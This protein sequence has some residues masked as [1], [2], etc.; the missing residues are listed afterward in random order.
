MLKRVHLICNSHI[1][2]IWQ[3]E[4]EEGAAAAIATF[5]SAVNLADKYDYI[6]CHNEVTLYK[7]TQRFAPA[8][9]EDI[10]RLVKE[11][12]W[13]IMGGWYLQPDCLLPE[14]EGFIRQIQTG[15][16]YF[17]E[18]FG[19]E[20]PTVA[21]NFDAF[22]HSRGV[23][24][25]VKKCGQNGYLFMRP[26]SSYIKEQLRLPAECFLWEGYDGSVIKAAR[27]TDYCSVMGE[28]RAKIERDIEYQK[29]TEIGLACWGLGNHGG[30]PSAKDLEDIAALM[31]ESDIEI[32]HST[33]ERYFADV[34]PEKVFAESLIPCM[35]G[36]YTSMIHLK[37]RYRELERQL[38]FTEKIASAAALEKRFPYPAE[39]VADAVEAMLNVQFHDVLPG[40]TIRSGEENG[41]TFTEHGIHL[42]NQVR[43]DAF[44]ALC[45]GQTPA[46]AGVYPI[47][48]FNPKAYGGR[49][50]AECELSISATEAFEEE[51][52]QIELFDES[53]NAVPCQ[54]V[55]EG[56]NQ[57]VDRRKRFVF[58]TD[59]APFGIT[60]LTA[61]SVLKKKPRYRTEGDVVYA[62]AGKKIVIGAKTGLIESF[63]VRGTEYAAGGLFAPICYEDTPDPWGMRQTHVGD[64]PKRFRLMKKPDGV[65]K[66]M[67]PLQIVEDGAVYL[68]AEAFF[69]CGPTRLRIGYKI[70]KNN[71]FADID[72][73]LFPAETDKAYKLCLPIEAESFIGEQVFGEEALFTDGREC[74]AHNYIALKKKE[75]YF[76]IVTPSTYGCSYKDGKAYITLLKTATYCAHPAGERPLLREGIFIDKIDMRQCD[77][78]FRIQP[79]KKNELKRNADVFVEKPYAINVFPTG[80]DCRGAMPFKIALDN[81]DI[82]VVTVKKSEQKDGYIIRLFNGKETPDSAALIFGGVGKKFDFGKFEVKTILFDGNR[83]QE[84]DKMYI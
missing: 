4:W 46:E 31:R 7:Y 24:Q 36:C 70:Y 8:L 48:V 79:A 22:G 17:K 30:G 43:A 38:L 44:F 9:F 28:S 54:T 19:I 49:Q 68:G 64:R 50:I 67:S 29:D 27:V 71:D 35:V 40:T 80:E 34:A 53:G 65:F 5:Q 51:Y 81:P 26:W 42:L 82:S 66:G 20:Q 56:S 18:K 61:K 84:C 37:Q 32:L 23:V 55:K 73:T 33:P 77:Y 58:E 76:E 2:H 74:V 69:A 62:D 47:F 78:S 41:V 15:N 75:G 16:L 21:I 3:W 59:L 60:R 12:K 6:F 57:S 39:T 13:H 11:G 52:S 72:V 45:R 10:K 83:L 63:S 1:D 25:V 14:G